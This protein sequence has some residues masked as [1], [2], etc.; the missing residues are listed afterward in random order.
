MTDTPFTFSNF[1][2]FFANILDI[3]NNVHVQEIMHTITAYL[4]SALSCN[5]LCILTIKNTTCKTKLIKL[6]CDGCNGDII[7]ENVK[8][9]QFKK[10]SSQAFTYTMTH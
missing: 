9:C 2:H 1:G 5:D 6:E 10:P 7:A 8:S 4:K 3:V